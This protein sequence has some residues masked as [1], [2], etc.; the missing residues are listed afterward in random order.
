MIRR[1]SVAFAQKANDGQFFKV[2]RNDHTPTL[3]HE[4]VDDKAGHQAQV[5]GCPS[6]CPQREAT[7]VDDRQLLLSHDED[8]RR[9]GEERLLYWFSRYTSAP[10]LFFLSF[11]RLRVFSVSVSSFHTKRNGLIVTPLH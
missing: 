7:Q 9:G 3:S 4:Q 6:G 2:N 8:S 1:V 10:F 5:T 11:F